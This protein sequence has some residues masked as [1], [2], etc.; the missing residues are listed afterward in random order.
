MQQWF[1]M[2]SLA[3]MPL[4]GDDSSIWANP[5]RIADGKGVS[6]HIPDLIHVNGRSDLDPVTTWMFETFV[7]RR[8]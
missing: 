7:S 4:E 2:N 1:E 5:D 3:D 6:R 8:W